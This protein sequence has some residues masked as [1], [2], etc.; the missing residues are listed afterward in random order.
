[1]YA[2]TTKE[3][4]NEFLLSLNLIDDNTN[5]K[6]KI[7]KLYSISNNIENN[8][9]IYKIK[10]HTGE[11]RTIYEPEY[12]LKQIQKNIL[13]NV[14]EKKKISKYAKAYYKEA[15]IIDNAV[16]HINKKIIL[17][18]DIKDFF[19]NIDFIKIYNKCF[20]IEYYPPQIGTILTK[21][22]TYY[23]FLPQGSPTAPYISNLVMKD[24]DEQIG[25][26]CKSK[27]IS[28][29]RYSDDMTFSGDFNIKE[30]IKKVKGLLLKEGLYLNKKKIKIITQ[31]N[32][33]SVTGITVNQKPQVAVDYRK[34]IRKDIYYIKKYGLSSHMSKTNVKISDKE[35]LKRLLGRINY[36][37]QINCKD[38][39]FT[40]YKNYI[41]ELIK[42]PQN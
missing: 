34:E 18:L 14:L 35:Y 36:V 3:Q 28:Y 21:L 37:L 19:N 6:E 29:T 27:N 12:N 42:N 39:Q 22:C 11:Y 25:S 41:I 5:N 4:C 32:R 33:Q 10:K 40:K 2:Y 7:R 8:Y 15:K 9:R 1:M 17:K 13:H 26:Y 24:F 20:P 38:E 30:I 16:E 23:D 31:K